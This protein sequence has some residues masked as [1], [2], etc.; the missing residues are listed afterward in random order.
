MHKP[1]FLPRI[2]KCR[3]SRFFRHISFRNMQIGAQRM[4]KD[5]VK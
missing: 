3:K 1:A 5:V 2:G 4:Q